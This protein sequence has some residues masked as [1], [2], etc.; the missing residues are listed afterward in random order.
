MEN[1]GIENS[2][3]NFMIT[4]LVNRHTHVTMPYFCESNR[5]QGVNQTI[6]EKK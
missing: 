1:T 5:N 3:P 4:L 2:L 6:Y